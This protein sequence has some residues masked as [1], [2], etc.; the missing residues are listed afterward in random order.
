MISRRPF[1]LVA[2]FAAAVALLGAVIP[3]QRYGSGRDTFAVAKGQ[4]LKTTFTATTDEAYIFVGGLAITMLFEPDPD[5]AGAVGS[6][7]VQ[8]CTEADEDGD[9]VFDATSC[10]DLVIFDSDANGLP[11]SNTLDGTTGQSGT[12]TYIGIA[13]WLRYDATD[14]TNEPRIVTCAQG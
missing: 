11:D 5:G 13:G 3:S 7:D 2:L 12:A 6:V 14:V 4:C 9:G 10:V 1:T 8:A